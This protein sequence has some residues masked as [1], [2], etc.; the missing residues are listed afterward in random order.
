MRVAT[1]GSRVRRDTGRYA[2]QTTRHS[3]YKRTS[4]TFNIAAQTQSDK[5]QKWRSFLTDEAAMAIE[6]LI[7]EAFPPSSPLSQ[8][9]A[10]TWSITAAGSAAETAA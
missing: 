5:L 4:H 8:R 9:Y 7:R 2:S 1:Y 6:E 3:P 10:P